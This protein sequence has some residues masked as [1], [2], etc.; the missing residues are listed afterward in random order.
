VQ[1]VVKTGID[2]G[3]IFVTLERVS[4]RIAWDVVG[5]VGNKHL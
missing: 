5:V 1:Y 4:M 3:I 2:L